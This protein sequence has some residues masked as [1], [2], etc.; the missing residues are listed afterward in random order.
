MVN[1]IKSN[2]F[3]EKSKAKKQLIK[4]REKEEYNNE[5]IKEIN[6]VSVSKKYRIVGSASIKNVLYSSDYDLN[7][8]I[9]ENKKTL[10]EALK[11]VYKIFLDK[12]KYA[13]VKSNKTYIMDFKCGVDSNGNAIR[14][15]Y[16]D[17]KKGRKGDYNFIDCLIQGG[18]NLVK[19]DVISFFNG[20]FLEI[21]D[22][23]Y[24]NVKGHKNYEE[25]TKEEINKS[26]KDEENE[27][28]KEGNYYKS[29]KRLFSQERI[30]NNGKITPLIEKLLNF[31]NSDIGIMGKAK[32]DLDV[33]IDLLDKYPNRVYKEDIQSAIQ[34]IK[35]SLSYVTNI[36]INNIIKDLDKIKNIKELERIRDNILKIINNEAYNCFFK[37]SKLKN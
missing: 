8:Y 12:F 10:D 35:Y 9:I 28:I 20:K 36:N 26:L 31:F 33:I 11:H 25:L 34:S 19:L 13:E 17:M 2:C 1:I 16:E 7:E 29:L 21:S 14:W 27:L 37:K 15:N 3:L 23:Y 24:L 22:I 6:F 5:I 4:E 18:K 32:S 30:K